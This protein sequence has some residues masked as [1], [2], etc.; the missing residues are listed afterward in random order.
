MKL[1][2]SPLCRAFFSV[3]ALITL[4][5]C[6]GKS[7]SGP[8]PTVSPSIN[9]GPTPTPTPT[10]DPPVSASCVKIGY[11]GEAK[12]CPMEVAQFQQQ[13]DG[14]IRTLQHD[15][16][17]IFNGNYIQSLGSYYVGLIKILDK[18]GICAGYDGEELAVKTDNVSNEQYDIETAGGQVRFGPVSYRATCYPAAFPV[19]PGPPIPPPP[20]CSLP[21]SAPVACGRDGSEGKY[22]GDVNVAIGEVLQARPELFDYSDKSNINA[23]RDGLPAIRDLQAYATAVAEATTRKG[24]CSRWDGKELQVKRGSNEF[25]EQYAITFA[26]THVRRDPNM[27]RSSC[28]PAAF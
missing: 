10:A 6:G 15:R 20:G 18:Q 21:P 27:Y 3:L 7:P 8:G 17:E 26:L 23:A 24:Y 25:N 13:V 2:G 1:P 5:V 11:G 4:S 12:K 28:F 9:P 14:A 16:P 19:P 22:Y